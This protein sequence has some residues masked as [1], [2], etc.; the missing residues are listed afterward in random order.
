RRAYFIFTSGATG[1]AKG[2]MVPHGGLANLV[3]AQIET[4]ALDAT[5]VVLQFAPLSFDAS[6]SEVFTALAAGATLCLA[7]RDELAPG[8]RLV[9]LSKRHGVTVATL[10]P[11]SLS[12]LDPADFPTLRTVVSAGEACSAD[13]VTRW[14][15]G[16]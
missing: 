7:P 4:F 10:P 14:Q 16:R 12:L 5:S 1:R 2:V 3:T 13:I 11:S 8:P 9:E 15:P 6:V